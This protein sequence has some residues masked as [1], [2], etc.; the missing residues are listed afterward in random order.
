ML[1]GT[2]ISSP[3]FALALPTVITGIPTRSASTVIAPVTTVSAVTTSPF[4]S[5]QPLKMYPANIGDTGSVPIVL[6][7]ATCI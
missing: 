3:A 7:S 6:P 2:I 5:S 4:S 1:T